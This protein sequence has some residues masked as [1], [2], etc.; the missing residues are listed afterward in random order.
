MKTIIFYRSS[1]RGN[2]LKIAESMKDALSA[3]LVSI[4]SNPSIDLSD[5]DLIGFGSAIN[6]AAHD[7]RL[8][9]FVTSQNLK[10]KNVFIFSTRCR[11]FLGAYHSPLKKIIE[12]KGG[13]IVGE[14]SCRG[15]DRTGPWVLMDGYNKARPNER[16]MFKAR[17]FSEKLRW[18][19]HP[20]AFVCKNPIAGYSESIPIRRKGSYIVAGNKVVFLNTS[21]CIKCGKCINVCPM[22][23]FSLKD[24]ALP[25]DEKNCIQC[26]LC[27]DNCP[28]FSIYIQESFLNGLRIALRESFSNKLQNNYKA[29]DNHH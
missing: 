14:F 18:K 11:P 10:G 25:M 13:I 3:E 2:T 1:Y 21:T 12:R 6:F 9:R 5:Y 17:L 16:D 27:A 26:R 29:E 7:I 4:D 22:H 23:I 20:L 15:F 8:Q 19:L 24:T 28:T